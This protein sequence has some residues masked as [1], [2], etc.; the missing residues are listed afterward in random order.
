MCNLKKSISLK[1][2]AVYTRGWG[3]EGQGRDMGMLIEKFK[4]PISMEGHIFV[5]NYTT[6]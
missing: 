4:V 5:I 1:Q 2:R 3:G 6:E